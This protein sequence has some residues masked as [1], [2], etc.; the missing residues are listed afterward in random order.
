M[1]IKVKESNVKSVNKF[2]EEFVEKACKNAIDMCKVA[3]KVK[4]GSIYYDDV[5][6]EIIKGENK[7][8][9]SILLLSKYDFVIAQGIILSDGSVYFVGMCYSEDVKFIN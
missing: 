8:T 6:L 4:V 9:T 2:S 7:Y 3:K 1:K 5:N